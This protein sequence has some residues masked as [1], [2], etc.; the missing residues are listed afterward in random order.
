MDGQKAKARKFRDLHRKNDPLVLFNVWDAGSA[1]AVAE[2]G[3]KALATSSWAVAAA[4]GYEDGEKMPW[5]ASLDNI[6]RILAV[7]DL[8]LTVDLEGGYGDIS[9]TVRDAVSAGAIGFNLEDLDSGSKKI[10]PV[11]EQSERIRQARVAADGVVEG[12]FLNA[13]TDLFLWT[14]PS[15]HTDEMLAEALKRAEAY[16]KS[17]ADGFFAPG[18]ADPEK[19]ARLCSRSP[20]PV[21]LMSAHGGTPIK[22][23]AKLGVSRISYGPSSYLV[24]MKALK[25]AAAAQV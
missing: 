3:A 4:H 5:A 2:A 18:L 21:N 15:A 12:A 7:T 14:D 6:R 10:L 19:I 9:R 22:T 1:G 8:P 24:A 23:L 20:L 17:G 11:A 16:A 13:R 25:E